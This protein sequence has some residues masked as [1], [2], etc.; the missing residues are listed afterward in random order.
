MCLQKNTKKNERLFD[1]SV[2]LQHLDSAEGVH[3]L[4]EQ[5]YENSA[6]R[7][8][9]YFM[10][11]DFNRQ[12]VRHFEQT[13]VELSN[14]AGNTLLDFSRRAHSELWFSVRGRDEDVGTLSL[15]L[16]A[17]RIGRAVVHEC[18]PCVA[19]RLAA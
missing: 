10:L 1:E 18:L 9:G 8:L 12:A 19:A 15:T 6:L 2:R 11:L 14:V 4:L 7:C 5:R 17:R 3:R 13:C 16:R